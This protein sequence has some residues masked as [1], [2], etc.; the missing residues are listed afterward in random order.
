APTGDPTIPTSN[1]MGVPPE[2]MTVQHGSNTLSMTGPNSQGTMELTTQDGTG[3]P[4]TYDIAFGNG[5]TGTSTATPAPTA[6]QAGTPTG[7]DGVQHITPGPDGKAVIHDG[8][9]TITAQ[10]QPGGQ[11]KITVDDGSGQP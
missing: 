10:E 3:Q 9:T 6:T 4:K 5:T 1:P 2:T 7:S 11:V 8:N